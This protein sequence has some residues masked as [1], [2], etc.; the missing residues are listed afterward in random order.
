MHRLL[1]LD[2]SLEFITP[3]ERIF[4]CLEHLKTGTSNFYQ[5]FLKKGGTVNIETKWKN[6][7]SP[8]YSFFFKGSSQG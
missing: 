2:I 4:C 8:A 1:E 7:F 6:C 3:P 5:I